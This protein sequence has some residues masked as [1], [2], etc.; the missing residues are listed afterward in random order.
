MTDTYADSIIIF[1]GMSLVRQR[2][3][4]LL[5][6]FNINVYEASYDVELFSL[7][8][9]DKLNISLIIMEVG[10][11]VDKGFEILSKINEKKSEIPVF[12]LTSNN[13]KEIFLRGIAEGASD[14]ILKPFDDNYLLNK[15]LSILNMKRKDIDIDKDKDNELQSDEEG[16]LNYA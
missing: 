4:N 5:Q 8:F 9:N 7:L 3:N 6:D 13:K 1:D 14:Y 16:T 2:V 12:I 11:D 10:S 15:I